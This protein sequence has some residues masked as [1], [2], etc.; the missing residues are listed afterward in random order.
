MSDSGSQE[1]STSD[2]VP[3]EPDRLCD[4]A[5]CKIIKFGHSKPDMDL[6][7]CV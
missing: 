5:R 1:S 3:I 4:V 7:S 6:L 2:D